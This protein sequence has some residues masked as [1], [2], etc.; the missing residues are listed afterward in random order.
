MKFAYQAVDR[1][2]KQLEP[3]TVYHSEEFELAGLLCAC[4][5]GHRITLLV[6]DSHQVYCDD[7]FATIRPSI[8]VCDGPCKS[9][10]VISAGQVEWLD[11]FSTE[12]AKSL[13]QKQILRHVANDAKP[14]SWIARLWKA[15]LALADQIKSIFGR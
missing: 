13:M 1:I 12:A 2:P 14:K 9:H 5:C 7:G 8:A 11:A 4:G 15:A 10:Y 6:P 3:E